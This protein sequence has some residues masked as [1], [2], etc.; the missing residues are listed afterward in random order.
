MIPRIL[1]LDTIHDNGL[2][3]IK[4]FARVDDGRLLSEEELI[5]AIPDYQGIVIKSGNS[6]TRNLIQQAKQ[7][8]VIGRAGTGLDN[9]DLG[10]ANQ[11]GIKIITS[12]EGNVCSVAE[13]IIC[14]MLFLSH[15]FH[16]AHEGALKKDFRRASWQGRNLANLSV[17]LIGL[18][19]IGCK[20]AEGLQGLSN[21]IHGY[22]PYCKDKI[23]LQ[24]LKIKMYDSLPEMLAHTNIVSLQLPLTDDTHH[25]MNSQAFEVMLPDS[26]LINSSRGAIIDDAALEVAM[27]KGIIRFSALDSLCPDPPYQQDPQTCTYTHPWINHPSVYYTPHIAAGTADALCEVAVEL[28]KKMKEYFNGI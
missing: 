7:L 5:I 19:R 22:D 27:Q 17:G 15:R 8:K 6:I 1:L 12:P 24:N 9:I 3:I 23:S 25:L 4:S 21:S 10:A 2:E 26:I 20:V 28:A 16:E 14:M 11:H 13:Y 18:G